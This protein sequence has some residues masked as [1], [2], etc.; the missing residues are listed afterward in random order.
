MEKHHHNKNSVN[1]QD[2]NDEDWFAETS[3]FKRIHFKSIDS[4]NTWAKKNTSEWIENGFTVVTAKEQTAGRG[5]FNRVWVSPPY[6]NIYASFCFW[7]DA[8]RTDIGHIPQL[9]AL[10]F[11]QVLPKEKFA[12]Q[13]K[14][15]NDILLSKKKV[16]GILCETILENNKRGV[17]C[18][19]G[20]NVNMPCEILEQ[21]DRPATSLLQESGEKENVME[22]LMNLQRK[23]FDN[24]QVFLKE[25]FAPFFA[26]YQQLLYHKHGDRVSFHNNQAVVEGYFDSV[27]SD[28][29]V[30]LLLLEGQRETFFSGEFLE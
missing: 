23:F 13:I 28:G 25:G 8:E 30:S 11:A 19:I 5:R 17:V 3:F 15:P 21:I 10:S 12:P 22:I 18:G 27:H 29:S 6:E 26:D 16:G 1:V 9:L 14:W 4:T 7:I 24:L 20:V 2:K